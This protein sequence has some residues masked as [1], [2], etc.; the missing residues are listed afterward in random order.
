[1]V[2]GNHIDIGFCTCEFNMI[3]SKY[4]SSRVLEPKRELQ[5]TPS[6]WQQSELEFQ[7]SNR[8]NVLSVEEI[9]LMMEALNWRRAC[10][11]CSGQER[12]VVTNVR[13]TS[14]SRLS[15]AIVMFLTSLLGGSLGGAGCDIY[16]YIYK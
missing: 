3:A 7:E 9:A 4:R 2:E 15:L 11:R 16:I 5:M 14:S 8:Y 13:S 1:M 6:Q 12:E 10:F